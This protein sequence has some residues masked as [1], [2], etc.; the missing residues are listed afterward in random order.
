MYTFHLILL[1]RLLETENKII[2]SEYISPLNEYNISP[3][4]ECGKSF[5]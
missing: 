5:L 3:T 4:G 1:V 2:K